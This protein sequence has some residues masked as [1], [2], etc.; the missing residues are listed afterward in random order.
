M[1]GNSYVYKAVTPYTKPL[2]KYLHELVAGNLTQASEYVGG[3]T[4]R[5]IKIIPNAIHVG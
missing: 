1:H 5:H 4:S 3:M 2:L